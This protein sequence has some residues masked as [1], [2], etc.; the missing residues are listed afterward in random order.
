MPAHVACTRGDPFAVG[1]VPI[2]QDAAVLEAGLDFGIGRTA[3]LG[4]SY[5]GQLAKDSRDHAPRVDLSVKS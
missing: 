1:G 3:K 5:S 4:V 2:T